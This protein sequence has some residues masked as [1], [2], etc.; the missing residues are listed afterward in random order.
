M[1]SLSKFTDC[2]CCRFTI[3]VPP[4]TAPQITLHS[5]HPP[6]SHVLRE[7]ELTGA[8]NH[9]LS[10]PSSLLHPAATA[11]ALQFPET[12]LI[13]YD[14]GETLSVFPPAYSAPEST[15]IPLPTFTTSMQCL[16]QRGGR[17]HSTWLHTIYLLYNQFGVFPP[18]GGRERSTPFFAMF[19]QHRIVVLAN[20]VC[21][22][23]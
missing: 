11:A 20:I 22:K 2:L 23:S 15:C 13:Q 7:T 6:P 21:A 1:Q 17:G 3:V 5:H 12:R 10:S 8:I 9:H 18:K 14:C 19:T 16:P 4:V